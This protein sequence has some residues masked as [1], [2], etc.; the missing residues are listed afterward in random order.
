MHAGICLYMQPTRI[1]FL[2]TSAMELGAEIILEKIESCTWWI[3]ILSM[4][5]SMYFVFDT[6][7]SLSVKNIHACRTFRGNSG[8]KS[9]LGLNHFA[10]LNTEQKIMQLFI[11]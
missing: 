11:A 5:L 8:V 10:S 2:L 1:N 7:K 3:L 6:R 4:F 9:L